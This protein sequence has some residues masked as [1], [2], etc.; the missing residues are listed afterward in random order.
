MSGVI[1]D[2]LH[3]SRSRLDNNLDVPHTGRLQRSG[4]TSYIEGL[5]EGSGRMADSNRACAGQEVEGLPPHFYVPREGELLYHY[6]SIAGARGILAGDAL[7]LSDFACM[8]D[9]D[10]YTYARDCFLEVYWDRPVFVDM[11]PRLLA[12]SALLGLENNTKMFIG[13][14][15]PTDDD[16]GQWERY[17]DGGTGCAIGTDARFLVDWAG[18][19]VRRVVYD[20]DGLDRFVGAGLMMLQEEHEL[21]PDD[22]EALLELAQFFVSDLYAFKR[23]Q[24]RSER[25]IRISRLLIRDAGVASGFSDHGGNCPEGHVDA[26]PVGVREGR[27]GPTPYVALPLSQ[28][29]RKGIRSLTLGPSFPGNR[30]ADA[31]E[32]I[33]SCPPSIEIRRAEPRS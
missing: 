27:Y 15:S 4:A 28:G 22:R 7:W 5:D 9:P 23:P 24:H 2:L 1:V 13:C 30:P 19:N 21:E 16:P 31:D 10:E 14:L 25:E 17:G 33:A 6:T 26:L 29:D 18:G 32:L 11:V 20:R 12:T 3:L 8:N